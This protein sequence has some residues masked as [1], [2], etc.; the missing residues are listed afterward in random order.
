MGFLQI[1][2]NNSH[3]DEKI[4]RSKRALGVNGC[5]SLCLSCDGLVTCSGRILLCEIVKECHSVELE[6]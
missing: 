6:L 3:I 1:L 4:G 2:T 5:L